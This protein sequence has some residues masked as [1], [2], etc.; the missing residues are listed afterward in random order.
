MLQRKFS[1][2]LKLVQQ[3]PA[4][5]AHGEGTAPIPAAFL[6]GILYALMGEKDKCRPAFERARV[7]AEKSIREI[8]DDAG[9]HAQLGAILAGL[10]MKQE[11][12][13][14]G[15]RAVELL[16]ESKDAFDG[17]QI[18]VALAQIYTWTG[19]KDQALQLIE[20]SLV[21]PNGITVPLLK[22]D[23]VWDPIRDD[24]RFQALIDKYGAKT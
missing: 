16:P 11:A 14:E 3:L 23:P 1:E 19:E 21:T 17:P 7:I 5:T 18:T 13:N 10:G 15:K 12:I 6:E 24:P 22:I 2:A 4:E 20:R 8:P 9:R